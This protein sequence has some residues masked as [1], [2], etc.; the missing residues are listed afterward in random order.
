MFTFAAKGITVISME[1]Y[2][3]FRGTTDISFLSL[4]FAFEDSGNYFETLPQ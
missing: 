4:Q 1:T 2:T 3:L